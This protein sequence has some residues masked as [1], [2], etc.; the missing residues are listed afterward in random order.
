[1][2]H[3]CPSL[4][5]DAQAELDEKAEPEECCEEGICT[6]ARV[7]PVESTF[8]GT[9]GTDLGTVRWIRWRDS[10]CGDERG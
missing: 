9:L 7:V 2:Y 4:V 5:L 6:Y 3:E 1:M 8:D 10:H